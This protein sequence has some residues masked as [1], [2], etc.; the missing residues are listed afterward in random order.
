MLNEI[1]LTNLK[2]HLQD[3]LK[4]AAE[5]GFTN[6]RVYRPIFATDKDKFNCIVDIDPNK[7]EEV[8]LASPGKLINFLKKKLG[9]SANVNISN[10]EEDEDIKGKI[11]SQAVILTKSN[12]DKI[13]NLLFPH[14]EAL[15]VNKKRSHVEMSFTI[16]DDTQSLSEEDGLFIIYEYLK[17]RLEPQKGKKQAQLPTLFPTLKAGS[18]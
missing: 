17:E 4:K 5:C 14:V 10:D 9:C 3:I 13:K 8:T 6:V 1:V 16:A 7:A 18:S 2:N 12:M 15:Q 11:E